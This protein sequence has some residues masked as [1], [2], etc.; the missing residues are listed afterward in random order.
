[1]KKALGVILAMLM[2]AGVLATGVA[3]VEDEQAQ[4]P[5][6]TVRTV[7]GFTITVGDASPQHVTEE[8][9]ALLVEPGTKI[10]LVGYEPAGTGAGTSEQFG[11]WWSDLWED[12]W[13]L[14][15]TFA[16]PDE[17]L[18]VHGG[19]ALVSI[20]HLNW[21][22]RLQTWFI[23]EILPWAV[24]VF[25]ATSTHI[26]GRILLLPVLGLIYIAM[27]PF[28]VIEYLFRW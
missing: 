18:E 17:D 27:I 9:I 23:D 6:L 11:G 10:T 2:M 7:Y 28:L 14:E 3:A 22:Q 20:R 19:W 21:W 25:Y 13:D 26:V 24:G 1:M 4:W 15:I 5:T 16:M 8:S 12:N